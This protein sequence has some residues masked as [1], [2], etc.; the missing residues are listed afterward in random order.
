MIGSRD[1]LKCQIAFIRISFFLVDVRVVTVNFVFACFG[2]KPGF[3][4]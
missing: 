2:I 3:S 1:V 4:Q